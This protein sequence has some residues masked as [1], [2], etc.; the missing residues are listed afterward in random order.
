MYYFTILFHLLILKILRLC[1]MLQNWQILVLSPTFSVTNI[2]LLYFPGFVMFI[3]YSSSLYF[4]LDDLWVCVC[5]VL[6]LGGIT[7]VT[8][9][10]LVLFCCHSTF[11]QLLSFSVSLSLSVIITLGGW[12]YCCHCHLVM[13][14]LCVGVNFSLAPKMT[15]W[16]GVVLLWALVW[17]IYLHTYAHK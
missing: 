9:H 4:A 2:L 13:P 17:R 11:I 15:F 7:T 12:S 5:C 14:H 6:P 16:E 3:D 10:S 8:F 1:C